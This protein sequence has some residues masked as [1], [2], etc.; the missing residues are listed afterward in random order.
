MSDKQLIQVHITGTG[1]RPGVIRSKEIAE[2]ITAVEEMIATYV[3]HA[4]PTLK[5]ESVVVGLTAVEDGSLKLTFSPNLPELTVPAAQA[6][7]ESIRQNDYHL[8]PIGTIKG[9]Q[10]LSKFTRRHNCDAEFYTQNGNSVYLATMTPDTEIPMESPLKGETVIYGEVTRVGG[11]DPKVQFRMIDGTLVYC[12]TTKE[13]ARDIG[14]KLYMQ[15]GLRGQASWNA[16]TLEL[17]SFLVEEI[18]SYE[19][20]SIIDAMNE[21][22]TAVGDVFDAVDDIEEYA[23]QL[24]IHGNVPV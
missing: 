23:K 1:I 12:E 6:I 21:L 17:E 14:A 7:T 2:V 16:K 22:R 18:I 3:T 11:A 5:K 8:L 10:E 15:V 19:D 24:R 20:I 9:L 4:N 13:L